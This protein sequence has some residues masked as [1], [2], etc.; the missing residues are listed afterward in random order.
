MAAFN[1]GLS[2]IV[3]TDNLALISFQSTPRKNRR[4]ERKHYISGFGRDAS[5]TLEASGYCHSP[6]NWK[7]TAPQTSHQCHQ[8]SGESP[9][10]TQR[11]GCSHG[12]SISRQVFDCKMRLS[13][14]YRGIDR[15]NHAVRPA[16]V[17][18]DLRRLERFIGA[19]ALYHWRRP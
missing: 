3:C 6:K 17:C 5:G 13:N 16:I 10:S 1:L 12:R 9:R 19:L 18:P 14:N 8:L 7:R 11:R 4:T 2:E 15:H